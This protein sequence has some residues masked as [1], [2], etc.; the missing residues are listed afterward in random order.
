MGLVHEVFVFLPCHLFIERFAREKAVG[1]SVEQNPFWK[2]KNS[3]SSPSL[4]FTKLQF[5]VHKYWGHGMLSCASCI[6]STSYTSFL[7]DM[8]FPSTSRF[9]KWPL[10]FRFYTKVLCPSVIFS[11]CTTRAVHVEFVWRRMQIMKLFICNF[12]CPA[13]TSSLLGP[14]I[15]VSTLFWRTL[16][17]S[18]FRRGRNQRKNK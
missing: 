4:W 8:F 12:L 11:T 18:S 3:A 14:N 15:F 9:L 7:W 2:T 10:T 13:V 16:T 5:R 1:N 17:L 6:Q